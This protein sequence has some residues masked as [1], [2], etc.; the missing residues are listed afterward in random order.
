MAERFRLTEVAIESHQATTAR[1]TSSVAKI[2]IQVS[3]IAWA[4][5]KRE[6]LR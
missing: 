3:G 2:K 6:A 5:E 1:F 4:K